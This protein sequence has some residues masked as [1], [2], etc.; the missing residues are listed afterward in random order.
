[1]NWKPGPARCRSDEYEAEIFHVD[2]DAIFGRIRSKGCLTW[3]AVKW[4][5]DGVCLSHSSGMG[6]F[7][8][9]PPTI[10]LEEAARECQQHWDSM[11]A[12]GFHATA[13]LAALRHYESIRESVS[14][15]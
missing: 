1:M 4:F 13:M 15:E 10:T 14:D 3:N 5:G 11:S 12:A 2:G 8:L 9:L 7:D 6:G